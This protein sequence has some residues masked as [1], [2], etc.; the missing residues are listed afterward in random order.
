MVIYSVLHVAGGKAEQC[1][2]V[3]EWLVLH[4]A[5]R[6]VI[7][8][9]SKSVSNQ[10]TRRIGLLRSCHNAHVVLVSSPAATTVTSA[11]NLLQVAASAVGGKLGAIFILPAVSVCL[12]CKVLK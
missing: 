9:C 2:D 3:A 8:L 5:C 6:V 7:A 1:V 11:T 10:V 12:Y 4:G